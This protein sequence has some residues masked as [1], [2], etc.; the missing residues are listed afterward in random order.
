MFHRGMIAPLSAPGPTRRKASVG[1]IF[2][3]GLDLRD[4]GGGDLIAF[5]NRVEVYTPVQRIPRLEEPMATMR[6]VQVARPGGPFEMV[7]RPIPEPGAGS[8]RIKV[9]ACGICHSDALTKEGGWPGIQYPRVPGHE[10]AGAI[11]AVGP[12]V[13]GWEGGQPAGV[14]WHGGY[15][16]RCGPRRRGGVFARVSRHVARRLAH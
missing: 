16:R 9:R 12:G 7:E 14:G 2:S 10:V 4:G 5:H 8:V 13:V 15:Y 6:A 1:V 11:D 3:G